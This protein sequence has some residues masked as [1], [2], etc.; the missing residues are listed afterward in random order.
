MLKHSD[1]FVPF[2]SVFLLL[3]IYA[4]CFSDRS[5]V[6]SSSVAALLL[7]GLEGD[8]FGD[9]HLG[10]LGAAWCG[11]NDPAVARGGGV[12]FEEINK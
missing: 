6:V 1:A 11:G 2:P 10:V 12:A 5:G 3:A 8:V 9:D 4:S 7:Q